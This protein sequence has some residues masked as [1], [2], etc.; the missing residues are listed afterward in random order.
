MA[1]T[2]GQNVHLVVSSSHLVVSSLLLRSQLLVY[3][4]V[5]L[6]LVLSPFNSSCH[7]ATRRYLYIRR[8]G[9]R[10]LVTSKA[11]WPQSLMILTNLEHFLKYQQFPREC[12]TAPKLS[13]PGSE[14]YQAERRGNQH[15]PR[16]ENN[17]RSPDNVR[18]D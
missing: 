10:S 4:S 9:K 6:Q 8:L 5:I 16:A 3:Y 7:S 1:S 18:P 2:P 15:H 12:H 14:F 13:R 17:G 11:E